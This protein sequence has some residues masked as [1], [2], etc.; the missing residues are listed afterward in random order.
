MLTPLVIDPVLGRSLMARDVTNVLQTAGSN[1]AKFGPK[2]SCDIEMSCYILASQ[3][4]LD[5][6]WYKLQGAI[7]TSKYL[8]LTSITPI[9][10][11]ALAKHH[12]SIVVS[13]IVGMDQSVFAWPIKIPGHILCITGHR[14]GDRINIALLDSAY[15]GNI[16]VKSFGEYFIKEIRNKMQSSTL[17]LTYTYNSKHYQSIDEIGLCSLFTFF[18]SWHYL[19]EPR[20]Y[21]ETAETI[22]EDMLSV[23]SNSA[24]KTTEKITATMLINKLTPIPIAYK[25]LPRSDSEWARLCKNFQFKVHS[26]HELLK[27]SLPIQY[28]AKW[29]EVAQ[30]SRKK[31]YTKSR[32]KYS[33]KSRKVHKQKKTC[34]KGKKR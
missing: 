7:K 22:M 6:T 18:V 27:T 12:V 1:L 23:V 14:D 32:K 28:N 34:K 3:P 4:E 31:Y 13:K 10:D 29:M 21:N 24:K 30:K 19:E 20:L 2:T 5:S 16:L 26:M 33:T 17:S 25:F 8:I 15:N 9:Q 11:A